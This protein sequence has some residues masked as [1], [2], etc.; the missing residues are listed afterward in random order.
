[1]M[2]RTLIDR[3]A[4]DLKYGENAK[5]SEPTEPAIVMSMHL[6]ARDI[7]SLRLR[8]A[9]GGDFPP[10]D[11]G[12][13]IDMVLPN[14]L[15]RSYSLSNTSQDTGS[16]RI[17][18]A[19]DVSSRGG[20]SY[21]VDKLRVGNQVEISAP[22][23]NF[24]LE[25]DAD[26]S[27]FVAGGIGITPFV[28]MISR[29]NEYSRRWRLHYCVRTRDRVALLDDLTRLAETGNGELLLN[30]DEEPGGRLLDLEGAISAVPSSAHL[31]CCGPVGML[32]A[33]RAAAEAARFED[34]QVHYE[35]FSSDVE[36]AAEGG[37]TVVCQR[38]G[39][40]VA[41]KP[42]QTILKA[43]ADAGVNVSSSC[44]EGVCGS[45]ETRVIEGQPDHRDMILSAKER[46][47]GKK[48]IICCSGAK[49]S[50]LVLDC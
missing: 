19:R 39:K 10:V 44:E 49:S 43:L 18:V 45:C 33:Y 40:T 2:A 21:I 38:S 13:H 31:Y 15:S 36:K 27:L 9:D 30:F 16:Y 1:M 32:N 14:G 6:E 7:V 35:Y 26:F 47:E 4:P 25:T 34:K 46:E 24:G 11:P 23:N 41:V 3:M 12:S 50:R 48:I 28:S 17:T 5:M 29:L 20:S 42:G 22:R 37:F 8:R